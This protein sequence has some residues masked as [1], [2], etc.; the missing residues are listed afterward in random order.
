MR[1]V[2]GQMAQRFQKKG[3]SVTDTPGIWK[4]RPFTRVVR[5]LRALKVLRD[6]VR[7]NHKESIGEFRYKK[8]RLRG[9]FQHEWGLLW[10]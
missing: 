5:G 1:V 6:Y 4:H 9:L 10:S 2:A 7:L 3:L 8:L